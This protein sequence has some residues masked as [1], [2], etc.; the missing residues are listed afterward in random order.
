MEDKSSVFNEAVSRGQKGE[1]SNF[2]NWLEQQGILESKLSNLR[3][4]LSINSK[5]SV[6]RTE[7]IQ[8]LG[9]YVGSLQAEG[10][11]KH[12]T[13]QGVEN[14]GRTHLLELVK[15]LIRKNNYEI[16]LTHVSP[17]DIKDEQDFTNFIENLEK[18]SG[19][20]LLVID[21]AWKDKRASYVLKQIKKRVEN[22]LLISVWSPETLQRERQSI[23]ESFTPSD[24][25]NIE[26]FSRAETDQLTKNMVEIICEE[27]ALPEIDDVFMKQLHQKSRGVPGL[28][29]EVFRDSIKRSFHVEGRM[30]LDEK[31]VKDCAE[32]NGLTNL[33]EKLKTLSDT[34]NH[35]IEKI[36]LSRDL[37][38]VSP[39][40]LSNDLKKDKSTVSY[41]LRELLKKDLLK[42]Q[43]HGRQTFYTTRS[44]IKPIL[45]L[46]LQG[47]N[48]FYE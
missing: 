28:A 39:S 16:S 4:E 3:E 26:P 36:M 42:K 7:E 14:S 44:S 46:H 11:Q 38:G 5:Y 48:E 31:S 30:L 35:I 1:F 41:H 22:V 6:D 10:D 47:E 8:Q 19:S 43:S 34:K 33:E 29:L 40:E 24:E 25:L 18:T 45:Q 9:E 20:K 21:D 13:L 12:I 27:N 23:E 17:E 15:E 37:R 32:K 2:Q